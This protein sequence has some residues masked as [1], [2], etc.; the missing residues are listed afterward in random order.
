M[1]G[2]KVG[3]LKVDVGHSIE[4]VSL[5][6]VAAPLGLDGHS[7]DK[8]VKGDG[9]EALP[10]K[11]GYERIPGANDNAGCLLAGAL[12]P[13]FDLGLTRAGHKSFDG[14]RAANFC[15][16]RAA[17]RADFRQQIAEEV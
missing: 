6:V 7:P 16:S 10:H 14:D 5:L 13:R 11:L 8:L 3:L 12:Q 17:R 2:V 4:A 15:T 9:S 1:N